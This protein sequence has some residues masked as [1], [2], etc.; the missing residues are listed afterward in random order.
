MI[1]NILLNKEV[2]SINFKDKNNILI[3][4]IRRRLISKSYLLYGF[5]I[6]KFNNN[7][8]LKR[9]LIEELFNYIYVNNEILKIPNISFSL[10]IDP[11]KENYKM[12]KSSEIKT[13]NNSKPFR[14]DLYLFMLRKDNFVEITGEFIKKY[15][16]ISGISSVIEKD[17]EYILK[18]NC[19]EM[20]SP[21]SIILKAV[22]SILISLKE[23]EKI[24]NYKNIEETVIIDETIIS[25]LCRLINLESIAGYYTDRSIKKVHKIK[26]KKPI[27]M[28]KYIKLMI[29][30]VT[31]LINEINTKFDNGN[32]VIISY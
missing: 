31:N 27:L 18:F 10:K 25:M 29:K 13:S 3:N 20:L 22:T 9:P 11:I 24:N 16:Y 8:F 21:K 23:L 6:K 1:S 7:A 28:K 12:V 30:K 26:L 19:L 14:N 5:N 2:C 4:A 32:K 15:Q 17:N